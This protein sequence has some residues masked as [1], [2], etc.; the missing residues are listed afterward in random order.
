MDNRRL[1]A[2]VAISFGLMF[3][4]TQLSQFMGWTPSPEELQKQQQAANTQKVEAATSTTSSPAQQGAARQAGQNFAATPGIDVSVET[5]LYSAIFDSSGAVL[6]SFKLKNYMTTNPENGLA[7]TDPKEFISE[8]ALREA[9]LGIIINNRPTWM[10]GEGAAMWSY[11]GDSSVSL[12]SGQ[13]SITFSGRMGDINILR[14]FTFNADTYVV[15]ESLIISSPTTQFIDYSQSLVTGQLVD[16]G[17]QLKSNY[18]ARLQNGSFEQEDSIKDLSQGME[19]GG[20]VSWAGSMSTYFLAAVIPGD[21]SMTLK[22]LYQN[23]SFKVILEKKQ[24][25]IDSNKPLA[26]QNNYYFGP[27]TV[28]DL[29]NAP[30]GVVASLDYGWFGWVASPLL[31]MLKWLHSFV[32]NWGLAIIALTFIIKIVLWPLSYKSYK[33]MEQMRKI[34]PLMQKIREKY[35][36]DKQRQNQEVMQL[37]KTYKVN[38]AGGCLP[39][40]VQLPIFLGL[41]RALLYSIELRQATFIPTLPFT[42]Y[43]WLADLS[44][45]DPLYITPIVMGLTMLLQ[46]RITP[47]TGDPMQA[48]IMMFMPIVFTFLFI[49]FASGLVLYWLVNNVLSIMQQYWQLRLKKS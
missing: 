38:P 33:S 41:Y 3:G 6:K 4:W 28:A 45:K 14:T 21:Q 32:G 18:L 29:E 36:D 5:P 19:L 16:P 47:T 34:Q 17:E 22:N 44:T 27:K 39:I 35:K 2:A 1:I 8:K 10:S 20:G 48:K 15:N 30:G 7:G 42:D 49:N 25:S 23:E 13:G 40:L 24:T 11:E 43:V 9:P 46:Q 37:Y 12:E 26:V 31:I